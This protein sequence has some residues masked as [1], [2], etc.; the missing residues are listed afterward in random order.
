M[1]TM[2]TSIA[3][4]TLLALSG[5]AIGGAVYW[6]SVFQPD[7]LDPETNCVLPTAPSHGGGK[8]VI[9]SGQR[10]PE[11]LAILIDGTGPISQTQAAQIRRI[12]DRAVEAMPSG[13]MIS[14]GGVSENVGAAGARF[15]R[16]IPPRGVEAHIPQ[17]SC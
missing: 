14:I 6:S 3:G 5:V 8:T 10:S 1:S 7:Q 17:V 13:S 2:M 9:M 15:A 12:V 16:C 11:V 4:A